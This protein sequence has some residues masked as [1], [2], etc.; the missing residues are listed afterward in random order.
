MADLLQDEA[1]RDEAGNILGAVRQSF[2]SGR[3]VPGGWHDAVDE[4]GQVVSDRMPTSTLY[5]VVTLAEEVANA[6]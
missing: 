2:F 3:V 6:L 1:W 5:H 4:D